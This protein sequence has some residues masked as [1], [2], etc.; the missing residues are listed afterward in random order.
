MIAEMSPWQRNA[1]SPGNR[2][3][4]VAHLV[5]DKIPSWRINDFSES[6]LNFIQTHESKTVES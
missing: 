4:E 2:D 1:F 6:N 5:F 3:M